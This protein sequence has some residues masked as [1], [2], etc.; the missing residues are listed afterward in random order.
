MESSQNLNQD[1]AKLYEPVSTWV[2]LI[3]VC[4]W[5]AVKG[6]LQRFHLVSNDWYR[7][8]VGAIVGISL[9]WLLNRFIRPTSWW[10]STKVAR[11]LEAIFVFSAIVGLITLAVALFLQW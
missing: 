9:I 11:V 6:L 1:E 3:G 8:A 2:S 4:A 7:E 5:G 10:R